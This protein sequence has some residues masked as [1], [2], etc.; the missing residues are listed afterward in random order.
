M[1][2]AIVGVGLAGLA[3]AWYLQE[4][5]EVTLFGMFDG[6]ASIVSTG[7]L[8]PFP[9]KMALPAWR[10]EEGMRASFE[11]IDIA[12][13]YLGRPLANRNGIFRFALQPQQKKQFCKRPEWK[14][15]APIAAAAHLPG[16]WISQGATVY[17]R[18]YL[19]GL[20]QACLSNGTRF[21]E[22]RIKSLTDLNHFDRIVLAAGF[23]TLQFIDLPLE[24]VK[25]QTLLCRSH[26][27]LPCGLIGNG[28]VTPT[29]D[30]HICQVGS[31]YEHNF[32]DP[33]P[34]EG[35]IPELLARAALFYP[36]AQAFEVLEVRSGIRLGNKGS[37]RP[38]VMQIDAR[39]WVFT[40]LGSRGLL[41]H[42]LLGKETATSLLLS[43]H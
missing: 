35:V 22:I 19:Q 14:E 9:G 13:N 6:S 39:T 4:C 27:P 32:I 34:H 29:E 37:S 28:H 21:E 42:A 26:T 17:S 15:A 7:L 1:K 43:M 30:P 8:H 16:L 20:F 36:P 33:F 3:V 11:L 41:Y 5:A 40:G 18:N 23:E 24:P 25:G 31:T 12:A 2:V 38:I 10:A